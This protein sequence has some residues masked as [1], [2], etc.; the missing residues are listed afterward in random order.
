M[1][2]E[3]VVVGLGNIGLRVLWELGNNGY[4]VM[5]IDRSRAAV[6]RARR[7]GLDAK[8]GD[9]TSIDSLKRHI[10]GARVVAS[11]VPGSLGLEVL[12][13]LVSLGVDVVDVSFFRWHDKP[14]EPGRGQLV[15][16]DA[17]V[18]PGLS[19]LLVA[20]GVR[21]VRGRRARIY[22]GGISERPMPPL[23]LAI[24]WSVEDLIEEYL[25]PARLIIN[26]RMVSLDPLGVEPGRIHVDGVGELEYFP[27]DGLRS[28]L[29][30]FNWLEELAEYTLRWPGH[31]NAMKM[32]KELGFMSG[33]PIKA[34]GCLVGARGFLAGVIR[35][36]YSGLRDIV[37]LIVEV[38]GD[39]GYR[40]YSA[41]IGSDDSWSAMAKA[42]GG[43]QAAVTR[44]ILDGEVGLRGL[45]Y[46][47]DLASKEGLTPRILGMLGESGV[48]VTLA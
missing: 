42:T 2:P 24:T 22:V 30:S 13:N 14:V 36:K 25:R 34:D 9:A 20:E 27:T 21:S 11:A 4:S 15:V 38:E 5:G 18:A 45:V 43:F 26:G 37:V 33:E 6:D 40:R 35:K 44:L 3:V 47:E 29:E 12:R 16:V 32:L 17:G 23:G 31:V 48:N 39:E 19:N 10:S 8:V 46:P 41:I 1:R 7:L 28:L